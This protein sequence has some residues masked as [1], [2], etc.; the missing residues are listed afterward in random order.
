[1]MKMYSVMITGADTIT[2]YNTARALRDDSVFLWGLTADLKAIECTSK[3]WDQLY[4]AKPDANDVINKLVEIGRQYHD[5]YGKDRKIALMISQDYIVRAVSSNR[6]NLAPYYNFVL[7]E[8]EIVELLLDKTYFQNW[9]EQQG[10]V[11]PRS[12]IVKS[13]EQM[14]EVLHEI[15]YPVIVKPSERS[16]VW[17]NKNRSIKGMRLN[18]STQIIPYLHNLFVVA[19]SYIIQEWIPGG[20]DQIY[21]C[22]FY[23]DRRG[24]EVCYFTARKLL[25]WPLQK[26]STSIC[27][28]V[29]DEELH[30]YALE[31]LSKSGLKGLGSLEV[32]RSS[33]DNRFYI[34]EPTVG[35][36]DLQS[37]IAVAAGLNISKIALLDILGLPNKFS[38]N[39]NRAIWINETTA[40]RGIIAGIH[41][42]LIFRSFYH[43]FISRISFAI[44]SFHDPGPF[45]N[46]LKATT[47]VIIRRLRKFIS[48]ISVKNSHKSKDRLSIE[49]TETQGEDYRIEIKRLPVENLQNLKHEWESLLKKSDS[50]PLFLSW[51]WQ[52]L[53]WD[54][55][56]KKL[57]LNLYLLA[58][59]S[60]DNEL[61]GL[62]PLY[63]QKYHVISKLFHITQIQFIGSSWGLIETVRTE[64]L[65]FIIDR[66]VSN[67]VRRAFLKYLDLDKSWTQFVLSDI[68]E[69][70]KTCN[71]I[72]Q[73]KYFQSDYHRV[74]QQDRVTYIDTAGDYNDYLSNIGRNT[75]YRLVNRRNYLCKQGDVNMEYVKKESIDEYFHILNKFHLNRWGRPCF[76]GDS[77][78]FHKNLVNNLY[79]EGRLSFSKIT[80]SNEPISI[81]YNLK[82][83]D[84]E[85]NI[86]AGFDERFGNKISLGLLHIGMALE[87]AFSDPKT[88][89]FDLLAGP[90]KNSYY[91]THFSR[92]GT[93]FITLQINR[94]FYMKN[95]YKFYDSMPSSVKTA[96]TQL[97]K[98]QKSGSR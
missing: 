21:F 11:L 72:Y 96:L 53:W 90:G 91:K 13:Y 34:I 23:F 16:D 6:N 32:K 88:N 55:W 25:Q 83:G 86:Q 85:Y 64:Y 97:L 3:L 78:T 20:D 39:V 94:S 44:F 4:L 65:D 46:Y 35:R 50:D 67:D 31:I 63:K 71:L 12:Y 14:H 89:Q 45:L 18:D 82:A 49:R 5:D 8:H 52:S 10:Y 26:G 1:M 84:R 42:L 2:G 40:P 66:A 51:N 60:N 70:S 80:I 56:S 9:A 81:L 69:S 38:S 30:Q 22:L 74:V 62:A 73:N 15:K 58:A 79:N 17:D 54:Q 19:K 29:K 98:N 24:K 7:P 41:F 93:R 37:D 33:I 57:K 92:K 61:I 36:N 27:I 76:R 87:S 47:N 75:R 59:Y 43:M 77:L 48:F 95:L 28:G 68:D